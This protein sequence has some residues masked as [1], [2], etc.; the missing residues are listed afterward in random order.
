LTPQ[1]YI[2]EIKDAINGKKLAYKK[3]VKK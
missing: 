3:V 2:V 1:L